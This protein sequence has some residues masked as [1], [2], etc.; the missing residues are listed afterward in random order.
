MKKI[1]FVSAML[2]LLL[3]VGCWHVIQLID[4]DSSVALGNGLY[5]IEFD[6]GRIVVQGSYIRDGICYGGPYVVPLYEESYD[7]SGNRREYVIN[8]IADDQYIIV[9]TNILNDNKYKYYLINKG[10]DEKNT[11]N[12]QIRDSFTEV[13]YSL[14][15]LNIL[16]L[17]KAKMQPLFEKIIGRSGGT[18]NDHFFDK[19]FGG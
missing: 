8:A 9:K 12:I 17:E 16:R 14:Q 1:L 3:L 4:R 15:E 19:E 13:F 5:M 2:F 11:S 6:Q 10:F 18:L 7:S